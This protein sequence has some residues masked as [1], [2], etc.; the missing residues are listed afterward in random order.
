MQS[1]DWIMRINTISKL[2]LESRATALKLS[3]LNYTQI[4]ETLSKETGQAISMDSVYRFF[5]F[6]MSA[7]SQVVESKEKLMTKVL[8][9]ELDTVQTRIQAI[10]GLLELAASARSE[11]VRAQSYKFVIEACT[12]LDERSGIL[13]PKGA[14]IQIN[15]NNPNSKLEYM[16]DAE[17]IAIIKRE[18]GQLNQEVDCVD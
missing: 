1:R 7:A 3:G 8:E 2:N 14:L 16:S 6:N 4:A 11:F 12:S 13:S 9:C 18:E 15:N 5:K 10:H 17:L